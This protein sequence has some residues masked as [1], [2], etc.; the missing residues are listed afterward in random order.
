MPTIAP[1]MKVNNCKSFG[2]I[3][4]VK[5]QDLGEVS[6][7]SK[8]SHRDSFCLVETNR[9]EIGKVIRT[10]LHKWVSCNSVYICA[11]IHFMF[12]RIDSIIRIF[13]L[14]KVP[15]V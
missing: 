6:L 12:C 10:A 9:N 14:D 3:V 7:G 11:Q 4:I 8:M 1:I 2:A 5:G 15:L 13:L